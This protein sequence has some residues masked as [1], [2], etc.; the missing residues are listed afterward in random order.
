MSETDKEIK[1]CGE[2]LRRGSGYF[3]TD[4]LCPICDAEYNGSG[5]KLAP[6]SMWGEETG[7]TF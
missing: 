6:R 5:H 3:A 7:E 2:V 4:Y 1:C